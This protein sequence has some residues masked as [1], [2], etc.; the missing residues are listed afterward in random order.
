MNGLWAGLMMG[1]WFF[2][3]FTWRNIFSL[4]R[5]KDGLD[6]D[7]ERIKA[8][9]DLVDASPSQGKNIRTADEVIDDWLRIH[10]MQ[11]VGASTYQKLPT[12]QY[13]LR[14][15][16]IVRDNTANI[17]R[18]LAIVRPHTYKEPL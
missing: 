11:V 14:L 16:C 3:G 2:L 18:S 1:V 15:E 8:T 6:D 10:A 13:K 4:W 9:L 5:K 12:D 17:V 7:L